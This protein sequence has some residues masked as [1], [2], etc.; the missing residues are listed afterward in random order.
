MF[1]Y[2]SRNEN[3][4]QQVLWEMNNTKWSDGFYIQFTQSFA[5]ETFSYDEYL[6]S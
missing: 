5:K 2:Q 1:N 3:S 6:K 4:D